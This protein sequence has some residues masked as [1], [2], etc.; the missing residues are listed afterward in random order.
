VVLSWWGQGGNANIRQPADFSLRGVVP[1][2]VAVAHEA[3][4]LA[5]LAD[6]GD[7]GVCLPGR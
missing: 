3:A 4:C 7:G 5:G 6:R 1:P 2:E